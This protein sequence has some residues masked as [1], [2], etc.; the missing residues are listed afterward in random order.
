[1]PYAS[2]LP[3]LAASLIAAL[4]LSA[5]GGTVDFDFDKDL[6]IDTR[7]NG[8]AT[9]SVDLAAQAGS[10]WKQRDKIDSVT[11]TTAEAT[12]LTVTSP[13]TPADA[14]VS[15]TA[16][17]LP[18]GATTPGAGAVQLGTWTDEPVVVGNVIQLALSK[19]LDAF[20]K[21]AFNGNGKFVV[22]ASGTSPTGQ[23]VVCRLHVVLGGKLKWK[24]F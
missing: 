17:L 16:W 2:H 1:M 18:D 21:K 22:Y 19:E 9:A 4:S 8:V 5:C 6:D 11:I 20:V 24:L 13:P 12:V 14:T 15:G 3:R 23:Q 7:V 10:A